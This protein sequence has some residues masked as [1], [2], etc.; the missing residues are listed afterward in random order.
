MPTLTL[1]VSPELSRRLKR[2][3]RERRQ[4]VSE[5]VRTAVGHAL[6]A[7]GQGFLLGRLTQHRLAPSAY[8]PAQPAFDADDWD[9]PQ[10]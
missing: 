1:K 9:T 10:P 4:S 6:P 3:A 5:V 8:D 2:V 7:E